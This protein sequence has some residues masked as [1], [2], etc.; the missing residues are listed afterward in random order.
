MEALSC[1]EICRGGTK[2]SVKITCDSEEIN[3]LEM[4]LFGHC[5][6]RVISREEEE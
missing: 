2:L 4:R 3:G 5:G 6:R 1:E